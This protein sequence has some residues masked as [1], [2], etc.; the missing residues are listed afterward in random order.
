MIP[1]QHWHHS[2]KNELQLIVSGSDT[3]ALALQ[4]NCIVRFVANNGIFM[5]LLSITARSFLSRSLA[6]SPS[7]CLTR[8]RC[9]LLAVQLFA[10]EQIQKFNNNYLN[11]FVVFCELMDEQV[12]FDPY[13][14]LYRQIMHSTWYKCTK[15]LVAASDE[16]KVMRWFKQYAVAV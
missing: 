14:T 15:S 4:R 13:H 8:L 10:F 12:H 9:S 1:E 3:H 5:F 2:E 11:S 7:L 16:C 6:L